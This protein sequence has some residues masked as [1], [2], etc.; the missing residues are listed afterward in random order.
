MFTTSTTTVLFMFGMLVLQLN[1]SIIV[2]VVGPPNV[3][4]RNLINSIKTS[5][6]VNIG[7]TPGLTRAMHEI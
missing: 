4:K 7:A 3:G 2:G 5:H 6:V 1:K